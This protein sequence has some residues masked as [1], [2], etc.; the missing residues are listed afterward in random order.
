MTLL[1]DPA[2]QKILEYSDDRK[3]R[4]QRFHQGETLKVIS[5]FRLLAD[6]SGLSFKRVAFIYGTAL[7]ENGGRLFPS[8][9]GRRMIYLPP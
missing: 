3:E 2:F 4:H 7:E 1:P 6:G 8:E 5:I 9:D